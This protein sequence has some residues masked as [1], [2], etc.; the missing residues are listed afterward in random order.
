IKYQ[1]P[2]RVKTI[3][4]TSSTRRE[5]EMELLDKVMKDIIT[6]DDNQKDVQ[7]F[8][9]FALAMVDHRCA[10]DTMLLHVD[11]VAAYVVYTP[12]DNNYKFAPAQPP[13]FVRYDFADSKLFWKLARA[14]LLEMQKQ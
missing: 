5:F 11:P 8:R 2:V 12:V 3:A 1:H 10:N 9:Q 6:A 7:A 13:P 4:Q 14:M